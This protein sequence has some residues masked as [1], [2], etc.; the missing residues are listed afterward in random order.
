MPWHV[1]SVVIL[2]EEGDAPDPGFAP[3]PRQNHWLS[4]G[5]AVL[6]KPDLRNSLC[7]SKLWDSNRVGNKH[8][9]MSQPLP[10]YTLTFP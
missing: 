6:G 2:V 3:R 9:Q 8:I 7:L 10:T 1:C 4:A 5:R